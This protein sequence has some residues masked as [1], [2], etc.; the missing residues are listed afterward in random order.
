MRIKLTFALIIMSYGF[1]YSQE[2][3]IPYRDGN[4][5]YFVDEHCEKISDRTYQDAYP[6]GPLFAVVKINSKYGF[7]DKKENIVIPCIYDFAKC[8]FGSLQV[9]IGSDTFYVDKKGNRQTQIVN[10]SPFMARSTT[11]TIITKDERF[12]IVSLIGDTL[13]KPVYPKI[14]IVTF[15]EAI[16]VWNEKEKIA[17]FNQIGQLTYP[18]EVDSFRI[19]SSSRPEFIY[20]F[21]KGKIGAIDLNGELIALPKHKKLILENGLIYTTL[22]NGKRGYLYKGEEFW[23]KFWLW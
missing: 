19:N 23:S 13:L 11:K 15:S 10:D 3:I 8:Y 17:V 9:T 22:K 14:E 7:I 6:F 21:K 1:V 20:I 2:A 16:M 18:F 5:W 4:S 12:G